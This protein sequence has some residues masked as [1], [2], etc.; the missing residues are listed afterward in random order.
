M[1]I[2]LAFFPVSLLFNL[3]FGH[4]LAGLELVPRVLLSTLALTP[5]MVYLFI[6]L[7]TRLLASWLHAAP[8]PGTALRGR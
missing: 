8:A 4:L 3:L 1:A 5:V 2:W 7:S 6:P